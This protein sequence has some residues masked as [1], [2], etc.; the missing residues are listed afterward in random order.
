MSFRQLLSVL[1]QIRSWGA[2]QTS[3]LLLKRVIQG[4]AARSW[5]YIFHFSGRR[6]EMGL[7]SPPSVSLAR[8][9]QRAQSVRESVA[10]GIDPMASKRVK[11]DTPTL[12]EIADA[13]IEDRKSAV[14]SDKSIARWKR[15]IGPARYARNLRDLKV[16]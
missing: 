5:V 3:L 10:E 15:T 11:R 7:G 8:A 2:L 13:F 6:R 12:G 1:G 14:R 4:E 9:R 16:D